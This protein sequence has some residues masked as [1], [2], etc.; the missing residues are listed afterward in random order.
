MKKLK[1]LIQSLLLALLFVSCNSDEP[2]MPIF[3]LDDRLALQ[4]LLKG[5]DARDIFVEWDYTKTGEWINIEDSLYV[6]T[7]LNGNGTQYNICGIRIHGAAISIPSSIENMT[8]LKELTLDSCEFKTP[9]PAELANCP[10]LET[11]E[12]GDLLSQVNLPID[13]KPHMY[14]LLKDI[15]HNK[16]LKKLVIRNVDLGEL[17]DDI[18]GLLWFHLKYLDLKFCNLTGKVPCRAGYFEFCDFSN[19]ELT[20]MDWSIVFRSPYVPNL[21]HNRLSG[22]IPKKVYSLPESK[23]DEIIKNLSNQLDQEGHYTDWPKNYLK[24]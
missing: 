1:T 22:E 4:D 21:Q 2:A 20:E 24:P 5:M 16:T 17:P 9:I 11:L 13:K 14:N 3:N 7:A 18:N 10:S 8:L 6:K 12:I 19:N 15:S 23:I